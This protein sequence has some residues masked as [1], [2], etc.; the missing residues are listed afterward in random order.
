M[1]NVEIVC[2]KAKVVLKPP[3]ASARSARRRIFTAL[4]DA[5]ESFDN[6]WETAALWVYIVSIEGVEWQLPNPAQEK[7]ILDAWVAWQQLPLSL[8]DALFAGKYKLDTQNSG[9]LAFGD[10]DNDPNA[11]SGG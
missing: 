1:D 9:D 6:A 11:E 5:G 8:V 2:N 3:L 7:S 4:Q 10:G